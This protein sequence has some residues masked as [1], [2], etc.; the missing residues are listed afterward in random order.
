MYPGL[1]WVLDQVLGTRGAGSRFLPAP[2]RRKRYRT[3]RYKLLLRI[4]SAVRRL[5]QVAGEKRMKKAFRA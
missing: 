3:A 1:L 2:L 4:R 5:R